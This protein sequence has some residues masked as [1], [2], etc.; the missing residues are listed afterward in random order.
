MTQISQIGMQKNLIF[1]DKL[2]KVILCNQNKLF[3][4]IFDI[5]QSVFILF[6]FSSSV[7][8]VPSVAIK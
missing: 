5:F 6:L 3:Q 8:S 7:K 2:P 4:N 1:S